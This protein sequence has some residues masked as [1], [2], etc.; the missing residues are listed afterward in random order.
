MAYQLI[1]TVGK[2]ANNEQPLKL[3]YIILS[4]VGV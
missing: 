3:P 2:V 1:S 4:F